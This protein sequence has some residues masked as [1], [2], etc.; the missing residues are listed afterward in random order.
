MTYSKVHGLTNPKQNLIFNYRTLIGQVPARTEIQTSVAWAKLNTNWKKNQ[1]RG[2]EAA[3]N[4]KRKTDNRK[5]F[6]VFHAR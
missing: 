6:S 4:N 2:G 3:L 1:G 5:K